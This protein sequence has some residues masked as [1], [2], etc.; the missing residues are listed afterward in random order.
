M[1]ER[2]VK[3]IPFILLG[4]LIGSDSV[5]GQGMCLVVHVKGTSN[6][7]DNLDILHDSKRLFVSFPVSIHVRLPV[8]YQSRVD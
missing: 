6:Y 1:C 3:L 2:K 4:L 7:L 5:V 8:S